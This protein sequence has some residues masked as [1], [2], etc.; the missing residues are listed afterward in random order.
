VANLQDESIC[1]C[2]LS[3]LWHSVKYTTAICVGY[4]KLIHFLFFVNGEHNAIQLTLVRYSFRFTNHSFKVCAWLVN[5]KCCRSCELNYMLF[6]LFFWNRRVA[7]LV[8][9]V[10]RCKL[11]TCSVRF[12]THILVPSSW[13]ADD[14]NA[15]HDLQLPGDNGSRP[16]GSVRHR[17]DAVRLGSPPPSRFP[18]AASRG[19]VEWMDFL[20][21]SFV[22]VS[23][24]L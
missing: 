12:I 24:F 21:T 5:I 2:L 9:T 23:Y 16:G 1:S 18:R 17:R 14:S 8:T 11:A 22:Y 4:Q 6:L 19:T 15:G 7:W 10:E 20:H 13:S 3:L